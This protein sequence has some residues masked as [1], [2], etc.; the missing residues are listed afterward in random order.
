VNSVCEYRVLFRHRVVIL[1]MN[2]VDDQ[3]D[4]VLCGFSDG[5]WL[6]ILLLHLEILRILCK[7]LNICG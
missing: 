4:I 6:L 2:D 1:Y 7:Q 5:E 3:Y